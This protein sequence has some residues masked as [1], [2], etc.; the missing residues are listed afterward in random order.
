VDEKGQ[1]INAK[2][3]S[4]LVKPKQSEKLTLGAEL[5][6]VRLALRRPT[7]EIPDDAD[8]DKDLPSI[9]RN[10]QILGVDKKKETPVEPVITETPV[11]V[12]PAPV[13]VAP[14]PVAGPAWTMRIMTPNEVR[15]LEWATE[16]SLPT[17]SAPV[18][19]NGTTAPAPGSMPAPAS[20][21]AP[22]AP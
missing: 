10:G 7:D 12:A 9:F 18:P 16:K 11:F 8:L 21:A 22:S 1:E 2:T 13:E 17:E 3:V 15:Q 19:L 5:G 6:K 14:E 20:P 4:L